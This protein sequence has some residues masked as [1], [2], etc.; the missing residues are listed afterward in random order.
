VLSNAFKFDISG[1]ELSGLYGLDS[2][3]FDQYYKFVENV[4]PSVDEI[5]SCGTKLMVSFN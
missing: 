2:G 4:L 1:L 3:K 5:E